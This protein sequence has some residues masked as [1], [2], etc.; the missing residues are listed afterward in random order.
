MAYTIFGMYCT[1]YK[2]WC[3]SIGID[4]ADSLNSYFT[5]VS[6]NYVPHPKTELD[7][8]SINTITQYVNAKVDTDI[9]F[10]IPPLN[11][12]F[13]RKQL[14][15][16][17]NCKATGLDGFSIQALKLSAPATIT[18]ITKICNLSLETGKFPAKWKEAKVTPVQKWWSE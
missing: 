18:S 14:Q 4:I 7:L 2:L 10:A 16:M 6:E 9:D 13:V 15:S 17:S 12:E 11:T 1:L 8:D 5:S 3:T